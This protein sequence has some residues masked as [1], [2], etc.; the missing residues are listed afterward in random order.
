MVD[1]L[2]LHTSCQFLALT[3]TVIDFSDLSRGALAIGL[4]VVWMREVV[5]SLIL[6]PIAHPVTPTK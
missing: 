5:Y 1:L 3:K 2:T 6:V 4:S